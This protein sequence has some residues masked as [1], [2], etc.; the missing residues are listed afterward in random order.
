M[1]YR[2]FKRKIYKKKRYIKKKIYKRRYKKASNI[3]KMVYS[4]INKNIEK[5]SCTVRD[6]ITDGFSPSNFNN[7]NVRAIFWAPYGGSSFTIVKGVGTN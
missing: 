6:P 4:I 1:K 7:S 3:K 5:K 2:R